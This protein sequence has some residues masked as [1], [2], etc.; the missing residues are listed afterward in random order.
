[1]AT[2]SSEVFS[3]PWAADRNQRSELLAQSSASA[4]RPTRGAEGAQSDRLRNVVGAF[5]SASKSK[6]S[7]EPKRPGKSE[8]RALAAK[9]ARDR[10]Q[11]DLTV[12]GDGG[13]FA[14]IDGK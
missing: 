4:L 2:G 9:Q 1:M 10:D 3:D 7:D 13:Q 11:Q 14:E 6:S 5:M 12:G 8:G